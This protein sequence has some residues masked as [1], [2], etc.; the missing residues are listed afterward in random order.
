MAGGVFNWCL[1]KDSVKPDLVLSQAQL[2]FPAPAPMRSLVH[3]PPRS[4]IKEKFRR[5]MQGD[6]VRFWHSLH[7]GVN[8]LLMG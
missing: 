1:K 5:S 3:L 8:K 4:P 6:G 2:S 7:N